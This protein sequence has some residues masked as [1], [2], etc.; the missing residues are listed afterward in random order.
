MK[1]FIEWQAIE[2]WKILVALNIGR[3]KRA[4]PDFNI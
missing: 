1:K 3:W 2:F 4:G